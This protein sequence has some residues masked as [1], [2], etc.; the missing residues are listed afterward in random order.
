LNRLSRESNVRSVTTLVVAVTQA[1]GV[2]FPAIH[3]TTPAFPRGS[4]Q[5]RRD[6]R[7]TRRRKPHQ[8]NDMK[9]PYLH[10]INRQS[11]GPRGRRGVTL[12]ESIIVISVFGT[13]LSIGLPRVNE[14][15]RQRRVIGATNAVNAQIPAAFSLAARQ[16][17]PVWLTYDATS[18]EV[19]V[20]N[21]AG[22]TTYVSRALTSNS[23]YMLDS[24]TMTPSSVQVFPT[25]VSSSAFTIRL[26]NGTFARTISVGRTG[27][28]RVT[29]N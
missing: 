15:I 25:S 13:M 22:D 24:V 20:T 5:I 4:A 21:R 14:G 7:R 1:R 19:R 10:F 6:V 26:A 9:L 23:E 8:G 3:G 16:R 28:S 17:K 18:G 29:V 12:V 2:T 11:S 27:L